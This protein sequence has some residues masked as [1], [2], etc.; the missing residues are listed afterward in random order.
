MKID[1]TE[2]TL[3]FAVNIIKI[4]KLLPQN[5]AGFVIA[6]QVIR[7][8]TSIGANTQEAQDASSKKEFIHKMNI[9]LKEAKETFYWLEIIIRSDLILTKNLKNILKENE[10]IIKILTV[11]V[12][13]SKKSLK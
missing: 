7:S 12:K 13:K 11:I 2:R 9:A 5:S 3:K 6:N 4:A 8:G 10:E 1:I